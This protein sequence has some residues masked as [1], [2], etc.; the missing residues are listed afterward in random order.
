MIL[1]TLP[2]RERKAQEHLYSYLITMAFFELF[3]LL[4]GYGFGNN[5]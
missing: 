5:K 2:E 1:I 3:L 4:E